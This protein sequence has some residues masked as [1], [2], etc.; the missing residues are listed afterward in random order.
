M[1]MKSN[2]SFEQF[3]I[4]LSSKQF[5]GLNEAETSLV[6]Q[7]VSNPDEYRAMQ[8]LMGF[9]DAMRNIAK[10]TPLPHNGANV[11]W[12]RFASAE[13]QNE[14]ISRVG[15]LHRKV[16]LLW[17]SGIAAA[18]IVALFVR[19]PETANSTNAASSHLVAIQN[20]NNSVSD[21]IVK[22]IPVYINITQKANDYVV[23]ETQQH[24][25]TSNETYVPSVN[26]IQEQKSQR[27]GTNANELG[28]L[29]K[30]AVSIN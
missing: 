3:E 13:K 24:F 16:S 28:D 2:E 25:N 22:E 23:V 4:L 18:L 12:S 27:Q 11:V 6:L 19:V 8:Q 5:D 20:I 10:T 26:S 1:D 30:L 7:F 21:T 14:K 15:L 9:S 29:T 17:P